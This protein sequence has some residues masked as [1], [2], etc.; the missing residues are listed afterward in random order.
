MATGLTRKEFMTRVGLI[1]EI[2]PMTQAAYDFG[3]WLASK[4]SD[5][6]AAVQDP[7][8]L[9]FHGSQFPGNGTH[10]CGRQ[11]IYRMM[12][13]PRGVMPR[14]LEQVADAGK[15]LEDRLVMKWYNAGYLLSPP[16]F[17]PLGNR[18][19]QMQF[20]D[21]EH[22]LTSTVDSIYLHP[23]A[24][25]PG[26]C[27]IKSKFADDIADMLRLCRGPDPKHVFQ[28]KCQ[29]AFAHEHGPWNVR[30]CYNSGRLPVQIVNP[31]KPGIEVVEICPEHRTDQC[32][33]EELLEPVEYG[34]IYYVSRD[35]P[36][37]TWEFFYEYDPD[38]MA[39]GRKQLTK[40][41][42]AFIDG[43]LPADNFED[44]RFSHPFGWTWTKS[45]RDPDSP[46]EY[47][48]YGDICRLDHKKEIAQGHVIQ[49]TESAAIEAA[50]EVRDDY[51]FDLV[52][53]AVLARWD[54]EEAA[55]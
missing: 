31:F 4:V 50:E 2:D 42:Q 44:K 36:Y 43:V 35:D 40:W 27:E 41:R 1:R 26:V 25:R 16:P 55:A 53:R 34:Y 15:D 12:D 52:R 13:I 8:H 22:W 51:D 38:F 5:Q 3:Q 39:A 45:Q 46:C 17:D 32:L 18:Q 9:S 10:A 19:D 21:P 23:R 54:H 48:D 49:L 14:W 6:G 30:R 29:I 24:N 28:L 11:A 7:W 33:R 47:C 37:D 20:E